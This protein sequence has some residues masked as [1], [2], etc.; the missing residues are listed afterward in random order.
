MIRSITMAVAVGMV[1]LALNQGM[2][3]ETA[4]ARNPAAKASER[5]K[6]MPFRGTI[7]KI[8]LEART[9]TLGGKEKDRTFVVTDQTKIKR[10][11]EVARLEDV[12]TGDTVGG[13]ARAN[14]DKWEVVTLNVGEKPAKTPATEPVGNN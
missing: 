9:V 14:G 1:A 6:Q 4:P 13:L 5:A 12:R 11:G 8:D 10:D 7:V 2:A 3:Q